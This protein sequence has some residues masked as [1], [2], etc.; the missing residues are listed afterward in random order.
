MIDFNKYVGIP[1]EYKGRGDNGVDCLGLVRKFYK[2]E[3]GI[4][5]PKYESCCYTGS[6]DEIKDGAK[7]IAQNEVGNTFVRVD[8]PQPG[9]V[10][11]LYYMGN[12]VHI[13]IVVDKRHFLHAKVGASSHIINDW[14]W[15]NKIEGYYRHSSNLD[16]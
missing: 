7:D 6:V 3:F 4:D 14:K 16:K 1:W 15:R 9:D 8:D 13:G 11:L 2:E 10:V 5:L 12:P